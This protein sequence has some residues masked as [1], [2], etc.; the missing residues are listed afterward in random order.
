MERLKSGPFSTSFPY[1]SY[2]LTN[3]LKNLRITS[4]PILNTFLFIIPTL[5]AFFVINSW[6]KEQRLK[7]VLYDIRTHSIDIP[8]ADLIYDLIK[9]DGW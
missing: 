4:F 8:R 6:V 3:A 7:H 2:G 5:F 1:S 9:I